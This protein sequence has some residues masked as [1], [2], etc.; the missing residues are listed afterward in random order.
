MPSLVL[1]CKP[2]PG[3]SDHE[4]VFVELLTNIALQNST[5]TCKLSH[6]ADMVSIHEVITNFNNEFLHCNTDT[7]E[8]ALWN[9]CY[10]CL[11]KIPSKVIKVNAR[12]PWIYQSIRRLTCQKQKAYNLARSNQCAES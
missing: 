10:V 7:P 12:H 11:N 2:L 3:I 9:M 4:I 6:K 1:S 8:D 5:R